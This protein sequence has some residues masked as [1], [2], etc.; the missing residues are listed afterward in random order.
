GWA[1]ALWGTG[2]YWWAGILYVR[3]AIHLVRTLPPLSSQQPA[4]TSGSAPVRRK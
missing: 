3:Q 4:S 2:L 1:F